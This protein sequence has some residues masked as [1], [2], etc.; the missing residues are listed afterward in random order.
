MIATHRIQ[1][2]REGRLQTRIAFAAQPRN[3]YARADASTTSRP[4]YWPQAAQTWCGRF[5]SP[6]FGHS[7]A[8][9]AVSAWCERRMLRRDFEVFFLGTAMTETQPNVTTT[10]GRDVKARQ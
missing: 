8:P 4:S 2:D 10:R 6:Q 9:T 7:T 5:N 1:S 3:G